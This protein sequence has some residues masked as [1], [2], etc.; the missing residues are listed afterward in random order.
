MID[1]M[2]RIDMSDP[3][4]ALIPNSTSNDA[5]NGTDVVPTVQAALTAAASGDELFFPPGAGELGYRFDASGAGGSIFCTKDIHFLGDGTK[6]YTGRPAT[7][8]GIGFQ[9]LAGKR[10]RWKDLILQGNGR[11]AGATG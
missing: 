9:V 10:C 3:P 1:L 8:D 5:G 11:Y 4:Y 6:F 2:A 7:D